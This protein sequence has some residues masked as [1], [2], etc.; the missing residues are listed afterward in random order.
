ML[1]LGIVRAVGKE[2]GA[3]ME[4]PYTVL[5]RFKN[6]LMTEFTDFGDRA[7]AL[8]AAGLSQ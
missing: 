3:E 5:A 8:E 4:L 7:K 1:A 6:G 2:S